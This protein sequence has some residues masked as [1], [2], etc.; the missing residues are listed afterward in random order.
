VLCVITFWVSCSDVRYDLRF[1]F[2]SSCLSCLAYFICVCL[3]ILLSNI[4]LCCVFVL[5]VIVLC[6][7][8]RPVL[9]I[10]HFWLPLQFIKKEHNTD[11]IGDRRGRDRMAIGFTT[12]Y[13]TSVFHQHSC[14]FQTHPCE[15]FSIQHYVGSSAN[16]TDCHYMNQI[17]LKVMTNKLT[18]DWFFIFGV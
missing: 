17:L 10:V 7:R 11:N 3:P 5:L 2:I 16:K 8:C 13:A 6:S 1:V 12:I 9:W 14:E 18:L 15:V 4:I